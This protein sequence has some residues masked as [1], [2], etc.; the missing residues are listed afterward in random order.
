[1]D[2]CFLYIFL[3]YKSRLNML[4]CTEAWIGQIF[5]FHVTQ[6]DIYAVIKVGNNEH[7]V[8]ISA[9]FAMRIQ[10]RLP[11]KLHNFA[12]Q[13]KHISKK[14]HRRNF[15]STSLASHSH[16]RMVAAC[17]P[18]TAVPQHWVSSWRFWSE[19]GVQRESVLTPVHHPSVLSMHSTWGWSL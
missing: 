15:S 19:C 14:I 18:G 2:C 4:S 13:Y 10:Q 7:R 1:M 5:F 17:I 6:N 3:L 12:L 8:V 9:G 11:L 16:W